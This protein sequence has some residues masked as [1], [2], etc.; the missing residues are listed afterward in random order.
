MSKSPLYSLQRISEQSIV[1]EEYYWDLVREHFILSKK[2]IYLNNG[3]L[4]ISPRIVVEA[5]I[6]DIVQNEI[7]FTETKED[8]S[9]L[10]EIGA[11]FLGADPEEIVITRNTTEG[12][13]MVAQ[14]LVLKKGDEILTSDHEH[15]GGK[16]CW[17]VREARDG[18]RIKRVHLPFQPADEN[19]ILNIINDGIAKKTKVISISHILFTNGAVMPVKE[20]CK[21]ARDKKILSVIDGAHPPGMIKINL[22]EI[23]CDFYAS[24]FHKWLLAP[25]GTGLLYIRKEINHLLYP[26]IASGGWNDLKLLSDRFTVGTINESLL[27]GLKK[28]FEFQNTIGKE[29]I[30][31]RIKQL[32]RY[33]RG[34]LFEIP[35]L[36][37]HSPMNNSLSAGIVSFKIDGIPAAEIAKKLWK[38]QKIVVRIVSEYDYDLTRVSTHIYNSFSDIDRFIESLKLIVERKI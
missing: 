29:R 20:I 3:S 6:R 8:Y 18:I 1:D 15:V 31:L 36:K 37:I 13:N 19:E 21:L 24:S 26:V 4:G 35:G 11:E 34:K 38:N 22:K 17:E 7:Y 9:N 5:V 25:K 30:E 14:G 32:N 2:G 16:A 23:G 28:A 12:M 33:L 27:V 10:K